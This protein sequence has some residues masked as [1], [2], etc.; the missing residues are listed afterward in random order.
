MRTKVF[1]H[2]GI[3]GIETS[4]D[5]EGLINDPNL[6][7][8][9]GYVLHAN[10]VDFSESAIEIL[11]EIRKSGDSIGDVD[12]FAANDGNVI[13]SFMGVEKT[14][15]V[16]GKAT[17]S[18]NYDPTLINPTPGVEPPEEFC[19]FVESNYETLMSI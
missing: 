1:A 12:I 2:K 7:G 10:S 17:G 15:V 9:L 14:V 3:I 4:N 5:A 11:K 19:N 8:Q 16:P 18:R 13:F 6:P